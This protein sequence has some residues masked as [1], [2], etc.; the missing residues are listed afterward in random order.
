MAVSELRG[1]APMVRPM[2]QRVEH[3]RP[4]EPRRVEQPR[5]APQRVEHRQETQQVQNRPAPAAH[6]KGRHVDIRA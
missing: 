4:V 1:G 2:P 3:P 6:D 5:A